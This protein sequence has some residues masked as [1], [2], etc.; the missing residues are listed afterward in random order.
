[1]EDLTTSVKVSLR[2]VV[3]FYFLYFVFVFLNLEV[4]IFKLCNVH[5]FRSYD[6][7]C[8]CAVIMLG[9]T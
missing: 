1:M 7:F 5:E 4:V 9:R 3:I 6:C 2:Y 8:V